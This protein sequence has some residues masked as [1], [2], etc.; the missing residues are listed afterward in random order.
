[1]LIAHLW[2]PQISNKGIESRDDYPSGL[3][4]LHSF[5]SPNR[6]SDKS[7]F[8]CIKYGAEHMSAWTISGILSWPSPGQISRPRKAQRVPSW[9]KSTNPCVLKITNYRQFHYK[10]DSVELA[11]LIQIYR[12]RIFSSAFCIQSVGEV[13]LM[14]VSL[15]SWLEKTCLYA[16]FSRTRSR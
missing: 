7:F 9:S 11:L 3:Q 10:Y 12:P 4:I 8:Y 6:D 5:C 2:S 13:G 14:D 1:M 16:H 15:L